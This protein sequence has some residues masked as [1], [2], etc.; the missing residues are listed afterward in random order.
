MNVRYFLVR[1][2]KQLCIKK[3]INVN[4]PKKTKNERINVKNIFEKGRI[5]SNVEC[6]WWFKS[7]IENGD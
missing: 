6:F 3:Q 4:N 5:E 1:N 2:S 7:R